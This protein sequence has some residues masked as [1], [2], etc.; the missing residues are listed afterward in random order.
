M[1]DLEK[2]KLAREEVRITQELQQSNRVNYINHRKCCS[3]PQTCVV[4]DLFHK[5][6]YELI[7]LV[8]KE[9]STLKKLRGGYNA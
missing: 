6:G 2:I 5:A 4:C 1:G 3:E 9:H 7:S 8:E